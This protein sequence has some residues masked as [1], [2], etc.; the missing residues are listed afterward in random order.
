MAHGWSGVEER[1]A[2]QEGE[3]IGA[4]GRWVWGK[5]LEAGEA[6]EWFL[7]YWVDKTTAAFEKK[8]DTGGPVS[9]KILFLEK[10]GS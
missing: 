3:V 1:A 10:W 5:R 2:H 7:F 4:Q 6:G 8:N 9:K